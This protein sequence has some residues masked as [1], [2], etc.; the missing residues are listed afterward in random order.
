MIEQ[1]DISQR[2]SEK[3]ASQPSKMIYYKGNQVRVVKKGAVLRLESNE[4]S[5]IIRNLPLGALLDVEE[6]INDWV[7]IK[8]PPNKDGITIVGYVHISFVK[9]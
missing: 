7:K 3:K 9:K 2:P 1:S 6:T 4:E 5:S 8:L